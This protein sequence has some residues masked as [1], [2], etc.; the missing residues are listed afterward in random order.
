MHAPSLLL[1]AFSAVIANTIAAT[2]RVPCELVKQRIQAGVYP[3]VLVAVRQIYVMHGV[4][5]FLPQGPWFAQLARDLQP[6][7]V[8]SVVPTIINGRIPWG[9]V[10]ERLLLLQRLSCRD[11]PNPSHSHPFLSPT[12]TPPLPGRPVL[13]SL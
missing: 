6:G 12:S 4:G 10:D 9:V 3:N 2:F 7:F 13:C 11:E 5:G 1:V 8:I